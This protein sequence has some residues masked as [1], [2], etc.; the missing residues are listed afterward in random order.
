MIFQKTQQLKFISQQKKAMLITVRFTNYRCIAAFDICQNI[1]L[2]VSS[3]FHDFLALQSYHYLTPK[4]YQ[5][6]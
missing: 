1:Y 5:S 3:M 6:S 2:A 4:S